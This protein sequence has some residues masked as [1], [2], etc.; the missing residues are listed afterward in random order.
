MVKPVLLTVDDDPDVLQAVARDLRQQ[1]GERFRIVRADSGQTALEILHQSKLKNEPVSLFLVDQ[2]MPQMNGVEFLEQAQTLFPTAKRVLLTAYADTD[3]AIQSINHA[4]IDYYL[5]KPWDPPSERL[6]P[7][8]DDLLDDWL[9]SYRPPFTGIRV[10]GHRW[11]PASHQI[12]D[13]LS[14]NQIPYQWLDIEQAGAAQELAALSTTP[15]PSPNLPLVLFPDGS[16][17]YH[18]SNTAIAEKIGLRTQADRPFYDLAIVGGGP[19]GLA[20]A[21]YGA[22][23]GL[24]TVLLEREAPG[25]QAGSSSRIENYL[26]FPV[27]LSGA[28]LAR[29]AVTQ[30]KR[31][32]VEILTP[33]EVTGVRLQDSYRILQLK[34]G[35]EISCHAL[36]VATGVSYR[37]ITVPG[38]EPLTGA[39][40]YYGAAMTE[41][42]A[43]SNEDVYLVG[44][45]NSAG[46]AA[47]H[48]AKYAQRVIML[49]RG[50]SLAASMSQYLIDQ[51][52]ATPNIQVRTHCQVSA[53]QGESHLEAITISHKDGTSETVPARSLFIFI[54]ASPKTEWLAD[55]VA[56]DAQGFIYTGA[57]VVSPMAAESGS[58]RS[59]HWPLE[60]PPFL[61]ETSIPGIFAAGDVRY[62][63]VKR[64]ASGVGEGSIAVQFIHR[65]LTNV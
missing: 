30:A 40:V 54:G 5:L 44:G 23:E 55:L 28:D 51:I 27:G 32:G 41:A 39:G 62:G 50:D 48:F 42:L 59:A 4:H 24:T 57:D 31:F 33:Q 14:R 17:L 49:V 64:V 3:A 58:S 15:A 63:S 18:P 29:R 8:L 34:D 45:A 61:L 11:S 65:Y 35:S 19:A 13:F 21:V 25:G 16:Q 7:V 26:G 6:Y 12:K 37:R 10:V 22:S 36:L 53:V 1:Y 60:R 2:R 56:R 43:C 9:A 47:M 46:Q 52:A 20:A 38:A